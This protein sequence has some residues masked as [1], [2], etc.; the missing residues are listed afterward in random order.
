MTYMIHRKDNR[1]REGDI[2][3][4]SIKLPSAY[5]HWDSYL[6]LYIWDVYLVY[7]IVAHVITNFLFD[8]IYPNCVLL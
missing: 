6:H 8:E 5:K 7:L 2:F 4:C 1:K 3:Y